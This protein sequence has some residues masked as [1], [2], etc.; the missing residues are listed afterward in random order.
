MNRFRKSLLALPLAITLA[1]CGSSESRQ[2]EY[3][4]KAQAYYDEG[5][6][7]KALIDTKNS[8]QI[9]EKHAPSR[10]LMA[11][12]EEKNQNYRQVYANLTRA[13]ELDAQHT[14][15]RIMLGRLLLLS[16]QLDQAQEQ[17]DAILA[18]D[19]QNNEADT[20]QASIYL[21]QE[22]QED[23]I[24][25]ASSVLQRDPGHVG[26]SS[27]LV[28][29]YQAQQPDLAMQT[30]EEALQHSKG[31]ESLLLMKVQ[32]LEKGDKHEEVVSLY[33]Q[34]ISEHPE[35]VFYHYR[36]TN[37]FERQG[38]VEDAAQTIRDAM[39]A[40]PD[41]KELK[42]GLARLYLNND[43]PDD[44]EAHLK[45]M[46]AENTEDST[47]KKAL[48]EFYHGLQRPQDA[49][50]IYEEMAAQQETNLEDALFARN[51]LAAMALM[52]KDVD[53]A[54]KIID[55][56]LELEAENADALVQKAKF[57]VKDGDFEGAIAGLRTVVRN[58][59][60]A[61]KARMLLA[62]TQE[63]NGA[64]DLALD[65]YSEVLRVQ[66]KNSKALHNAGRLLRKRGDLT[67][68]EEALQKALEIDPENKDIASLLVTTLVELKQWNGAHKVADGAT[69]TEGLS[70]YLHGVTYLQ[71][72]KL[73]EGIAA[74]QA[75]LKV[76]P[77]GIQSLTLLAQALAQKDNSLNTSLTYVRD[78]VKANP[79]QV[80]A[81]NLLGSILMKQKKLD[82]AGVVYDK[83][84]EN[85]PKSL[86]GYQGRANVH[87]AKGE[88]RQAVNLFDSALEIFPEGVMLHN[89]KAELL[90]MEGKY[91]LA[92]GAY[93]DAIKL[94]P[95]AMVARN[96]LAILLVDRF[97]DEQSLAR[98]EQLSADFVNTANA[99]LIDTAGWVMLKQGKLQDALTQLK[100]AVALAGKSPEIN[101]HLGAAYAQDGKTELAKQHLETA[102]VEQA[103]NAAWYADAEKLMESLK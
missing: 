69:H 94:A 82:E 74:M 45:A 32:M 87:V 49:K 99:T 96:N 29:A 80:H 38:K 58:N 48:A 50:G 8:L 92:R 84:I 72:G 91:M 88:L 76:Q 12:L 9:N 90:T 77:D 89:A 10:Y 60:E 53:G 23:A 61:V 35:A 34:L 98:A 51:R 86:V 11:L 73:D 21:S 17:V 33:Q 55:E 66:P 81:Q 85:A 26:A 30:I 37:Y 93:E 59:P 43:R 63:A 13:V 97:A 103:K 40:F 64:N 67:G 6:F 102:L 22:K 65:N 19:P 20:L 47:Y 3:F 39:K 100:R 79:K 4:E 15:S 71:E 18:Y 44:A 62:A 16:K 95:E 5:N 75:S 7:D 46:V 42:L 57:Q 52:E 101:Y 78:H 68:A 36:L 1:A 56:V 14:D 28:A 83:L 27:I 54:R 31:D 24:A 25:K 41:N 70:D 2:A